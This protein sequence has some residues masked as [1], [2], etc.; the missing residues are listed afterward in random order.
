VHKALTLSARPRALLPG[1]R[2]YRCPGRGPPV[3]WQ[4]GIVVGGAGDATR[5]YVS[6]L[7]CGA[8]RSSRA[9][10]GRDPAACKVAEEAYAAADDRDRDSKFTCRF[11]EI[12]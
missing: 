6:C 10:T 7:A 8:G 1:N 5:R 3:A 11:G 12:L 4:A 2:V 9:R